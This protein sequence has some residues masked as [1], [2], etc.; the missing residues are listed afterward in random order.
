MWVHAVVHSRHRTEEGKTETLNGHKV[1]ACI[2]RMD[3]GRWKCDTAWL[4]ALKGAAG[5]HA[6]LMILSPVWTPA[7]IA[8]PSGKQSTQKEQRRW[9]NERADN[10]EPGGKHSGREKYTADRRRSLSRPTSEWLLTSAFIFLLPLFFFKDDNSGYITR[11]TCFTAPPQ[12]KG[13]RRE[14]GHYEIHVWLDSQRL[15]KWSI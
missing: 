8:A 5:K 14:T 9:W 7:R 6:T 15:N 3:C 13:F 4:A 2:L 11:R 12:T 1:A 10:R